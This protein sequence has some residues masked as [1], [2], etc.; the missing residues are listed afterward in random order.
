[1]SEVI[2]ILENLIELANEYLFLGKSKGD[3][4]KNVGLEELKLKFAKFNQ[5]HGYKGVSPFVYLL[6]QNNGTY[7]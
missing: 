7:N 5:I 1:V 4:Y 3:G 2:T 6:I